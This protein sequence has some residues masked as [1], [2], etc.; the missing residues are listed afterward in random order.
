MADIAV[1]YSVT[2]ASTVTMTGSVYV[3]VSVA[4]VAPLWVEPAAPSIPPM[5]STMISRPSVLA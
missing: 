1:L 4:V 2:L 3:V 5:T